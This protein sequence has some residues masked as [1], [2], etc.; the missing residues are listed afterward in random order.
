VYGEIILDNGTGNIAEPQEEGL[1]TEREAG[2]LFLRVDR[3]DGRPVLSS[4][5]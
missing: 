1:L 3:L 2:S 5:E 4:Y